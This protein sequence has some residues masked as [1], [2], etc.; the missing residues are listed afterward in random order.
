MTDKAIV[1]NQT[2]KLRALKETYG[3]TPWKVVK[4]VS[5]LVGAS[6]ASFV[7]GSI[8]REQMPTQPKTLNLVRAAIG[9]YLLEG[10]ASAAVTDYIDK[11]LGEFDQI[12]EP[13]E[14]DG[15]QNGD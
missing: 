7:I 5:G 3:I 4:A 6:M 12:F 15:D 9:I 13:S 8:L 11:T 14:E 1:E 10:V 2:G